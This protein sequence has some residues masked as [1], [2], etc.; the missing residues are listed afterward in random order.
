MKTI[1]IT[2]ANG[3]IGRE[4]I[5]ALHFTNPNINLLGIGRTPT[6]KTLMSNTPAL[7]P[8][9]PESKTSNYSYEVLDVRNYAGLKKLIETNNV[10][11]I[12]HLASL[13]SAKGEENP[14]ICWDININGLKN[15]LELAKEYHLSIFWP[16]SIAVFGPQ[17]P[18]ILA[19]Q[20]AVTDPTTMY[21]ITKVTGELLCQYYA[22]HYQ[23]NVRS[24]RLPGIISYRV[25]P[26]G[27]TTDYAVNMFHSAVQSQDYHCFVEPETK[28]PFTYMPDCIKAIIRLMQATLSE[29]YLS[30]NLTAFSP[31]VAELVQAIQQYKPQFRCHY[32]PDYR[33]AIADSWPDSI[34]DSVARLDWGWQPEYGLA[35]MVNNMLAQLSWRDSHGHF[36]PTPLSVAS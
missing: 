2:G 9:R 18:K 33:Q 6:V 16:S 24:L 13:L 15:I 34:D 4:L 11:C 30:Y 35:A 17:T 7:S 3:Q 25:H 12:Y 26:G 28:L 20:T 32:H 19:S 29:S 36:N 21:G 31:T 22:Q 14:S 1:L 8:D 10:T 27:G 5:P 23:V